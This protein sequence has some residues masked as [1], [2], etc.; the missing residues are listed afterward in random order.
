MLKLAMLIWFA[1][2]FGG[3]CG[4]TMQS[5]RCVMAHPDAW[6]VNSSF[7]RDV[8]TITTPDHLVVV[9]PTEIDVDG[10]TRILIEASTQTVDVHIR[11]GTVTLVADGKTIAECSRK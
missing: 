8:A 2:D 5:G 3:S 11:R 6:Y 9:S 7:D 4:G 1:A 10:H